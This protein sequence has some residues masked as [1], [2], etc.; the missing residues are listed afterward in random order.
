M[1][2]EGWKELATGKVQGYTISPILSGMWLSIWIRE[3]SESLVP[4]IIL[5]EVLWELVSEIVIVFIHVV[6]WVFQYLRQFWIWVGSLDSGRNKNELRDIVEAVSIRLRCQ[7]PRVNIQNLVVVMNYQLFM[8]LSHFSEQ[9]EDHRLVR[10]MIAGE[11][12]KQ[13]V[14]QHVQEGFIFNVCP[15]E[16]RVD[17]FSK[18][19]IVFLEIEQNCVNF[20]LWQGQDFVK[21]CYSVQG[22]NPDFVNFII[23]HV[24][25]KLE[26][27]LSDLLA[28]FREYTHGSDTREP[29]SHWIV[30][31]K[32][33]QYP[34]HMLLKFLI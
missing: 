15:A 5:P 11:I 6:R 22:P 13:A 21:S 32:Q 17:T 10:G 23:K 34:L 28:F 14:E 19:E 33:Q 1:S 3:S 16:E 7:V 12:R 18:L 24:D 26:A 8:G 20:S 4:P 31:Q 29:H 27:L 25:Q 9:S 2:S 30:L